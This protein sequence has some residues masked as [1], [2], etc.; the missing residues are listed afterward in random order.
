MT[1]TALP[2]FQSFIG[3][4]ETNAERSLTLSQVAGDQ[5]AESSSV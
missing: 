3:G 1:L 5:D 4:C 2:A